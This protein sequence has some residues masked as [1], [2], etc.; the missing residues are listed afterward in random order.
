MEPQPAL[1]LDRDGV[2]NRRTPGDY[3]KNPSGFIPE[4]RAFE[5]IRLLNSHFRPIVVVTN[6]AGIGKGVMTETELAAVHAHLL[7]LSAAAGAHIDALYHC[8]HRPDAGCPCRKPAP[9]MAFQAR[10]DFPEIE[11]S[12]AWMVGDSASDMEFGHSLGMKTVLITGKME[13]TALLK[14]MQ[15]DYRFA[16]LRDFAGFVEKA[17]NW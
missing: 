1:F 2:I 4:P 16:S 15:I 11:F 12:R 9:G 13:E 10:A 5:A 8:P 14:T 17:S 6:Q 3:V 7:E